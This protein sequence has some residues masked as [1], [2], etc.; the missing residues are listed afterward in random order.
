M[1]VSD[2]RP[3]DD[4][5]QAM[6]A[7][8][9]LGLLEPVERARAL[10]RQLADP[11]FARAV[12]LWEERFGPLYD[13]I[14]DA[15]PSA[16]LWEDIATSLD[17]LAQEDSDTRQMVRSPWAARARRWRLATFVAAGIAAVL[18]I[19][20]VIP[21]GELPA[22]VPTGQAEYAVAQLT[23]PIDGL[24]MTARF[25]EKADQ[26][27]VRVDGMPQTKTEPELWTLDEAGKPRSLG[28]VGRS[29]V[30]R[31]GI[32][33]AQRAWLESNGMLLVTMEPAQ[34]APHDAPSA[35]PV[36]SGKLTRV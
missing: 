9:V 35:D 27:L 21:R 29:G 10:R 17:A 26:L 33:E 16:G 31:I 22:P 5:A 6:A 7:E 32:T 34:G 18:A 30:T 20:A 19:V 15:A 36:A 13:D 24:L 11:D 3:L 12:A 1:S 23:G 14:A 28:L 4:E 2:E 25:D 8:L